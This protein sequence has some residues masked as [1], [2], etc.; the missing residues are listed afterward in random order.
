MGRFPIRA[1]LYEVPPPPT[2]KRRGAPRK[3]GALIGSPKILAQT[4]KGWIPHP[5]EAGTE[6]HAWCGLWH[7]VL[8]GQLLR[9]VVVRRQAQGRP[10]RVGPRK[11]PPPLEAFFTTD[12]A[13][14]PQDIL[15]EYRKRW[16]VGVSREVHRDPVGASPTEVRS[17]SL[18]AW[19]APWRENKTVEPSDNMR[20][21]AHAQH[22]RLQRAVNADVASLHAIPVA[23]TVDNARRQ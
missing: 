10:T 22:T 8:P 19:E 15:T 23:E 11:S 7:P 17:S 21:Q 9:V 3:K 16:A 6:I 4:A 1:K 13:L 18:V 14:S 12:L 20:R 2:G 5:S